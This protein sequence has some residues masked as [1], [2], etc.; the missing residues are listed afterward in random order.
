MSV[1]QE[2]KKVFDDLVKQVEEHCT[3]NDGKITAAEKRIIKSMKKSSEEMVKE[4]SD[5]LKEEEMDE[6][7]FL[8]LVNKNRG[9][10]LNEMYEAAKTPTGK[11]SKKAKD[12]IA[13]VAKDLT[14]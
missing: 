13:I 5:I 7:K 2:L 12:L 10:I 3:G 6:M 14:A 11:I 4:I 1:D 9:K 8:S